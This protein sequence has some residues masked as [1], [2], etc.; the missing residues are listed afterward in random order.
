V[1]GT[2]KSMD[3][4]LLYQALR[5]KRVDMAA[6]NST[7]APLA[8]PKFVVLK[9]DKKAFPPYTACYVA[10]EPLIEQQ[11]NIKWALTL[12]QGRIGDDT[13]RDLNRRVEFEHQPVEK[14]AKDFLATQW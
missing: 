5:Q 11:P 7:D 9:D 8:D 12:L 2:P 3:L 14:V 1:D 6:G 13:M 4:G 10:R